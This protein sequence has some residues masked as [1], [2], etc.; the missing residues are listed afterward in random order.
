MADKI[1]Q[2][3]WL[4]WYLNRYGWQFISPDMA[5]NTFYQIW[6][7]TCFYALVGE[8]KL[9]Y[10]FIYISIDTCADA[11][12]KIHA[13][14]C[15]FHRKYEWMVDIIN[16]HSHMHASNCNCSLVNY[17]FWPTFWFID[18]KDQTAVF[19]SYVLQYSIHIKQTN[20]Q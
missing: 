1:S 20:K 2:Q 6:L 17:S 3:I 5:D 9:I 8:I 7:T 19:S 14:L 13:W 15:K 12:E 4:T 10:F 16:S 18:A 11:A